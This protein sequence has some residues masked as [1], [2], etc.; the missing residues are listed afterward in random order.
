MDF[1]I[2]IYLEFGLYKESLISVVRKGK[3]GSEEIKKMMDDYRST[4]PASIN[5]SRMIMIKDYQL[6]VSKDMSVR[7]YPA[8]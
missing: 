7:R 1:L 8:D 4:P 5:G 2:D 3:S 6:S